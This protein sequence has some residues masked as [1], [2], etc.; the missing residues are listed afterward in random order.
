MREV[1]RVAKTKGFFRDGPAAEILI[2]IANNSLIASSSLSNTTPT[3]P[4]SKGFKIV[5]GQ[6]TYIC[7]QKLVNSY[8]WMQLNAQLQGYTS[9]GIA[10]IRG[11]M[12]LYMYEKIRPFLRSGW[13]SSVVR[14][15]VYLFEQYHYQTCNSI[16]GYEN[17]TVLQSKITE[18]C[19]YLTRKIII[20]DKKKEEEK[21]KRKREFEQEQNRQKELVMEKKRFEDFIRRGKEKI[22]V[23]LLVDHISNCDLDVCNIARC[24]SHRRMINDCFRSESK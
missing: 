4:I 11:T 7:S 17:K 18:F 5:E 22:A 21:I 19:Y 9:G 3:L 16:K 12:R 1:V 8:H 14:K 23:L 6:I 15:F 2:L 24:M 20:A 10:R 13:R